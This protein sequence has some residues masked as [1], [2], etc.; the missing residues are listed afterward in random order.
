M[1]SRAPPF[2]TIAA[3]RR[4]F[5]ARPILESSDEEM[6]YSSSKAPQSQPA[7]TASVPTI[8]AAS[9]PLMLNDP[10]RF[11]PKATHAATIAPSS[12]RDISGLRLVGELVGRYLRCLPG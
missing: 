7:A 3:V 5:V 4:S 6:K 12:E 1:A 2:A 10:A 11:A 9:A 8:V